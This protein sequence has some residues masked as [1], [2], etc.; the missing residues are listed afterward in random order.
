M[1]LTKRDL[2]LFGLVIYF[3]F[4]GGTFYSQFN[5]F[6]RITNQVIVTLI[7]GG[8]LLNLLRTNRGLPTTALDLPL[9]L[10]L[11]VNIISAGL[12]YA[13]RFS[14]EGVWFTLTHILAFY[15]LVDLIR[16]GRTPQLT[17]AFFMASAVVC[18]IGLA[19][20]AAWYFG[21]SL[22]AVFS[23]GWS[24]I[25]GWRNPIPPA[26]YRLAITLNGPT[27]LSAYLA[28]FTPI[29]IGLILT[30]PRRNENRRALQIWL[31]LAFVV[32]ILT[33]SRA[34]ILALLASLSLLGLGWFK[35]TGR[36]SFAFLERWRRLKPGWRLLFLISLI[37]VMGGAA[38]WLQRSF[39]GRA[40]STD[41]RLTLWQTAFNIFQEEWLTG[42]GPGNFGRAL[43]RFNDT[44]LPRQQIST[45]HSIYFNTAA[46]LGLLG[47]LAGAFLLL[48]VGWIWRRRW[49]NIGVTDVGER[50]KL[51]AVGAA[52]VGLAVQTLVDT[53]MAT[54][55]M[56]VMLALV[57]YLA[58]EAPVP[59]R[60]WP[61]RAAAY[62]GLAGL[63]LYAGG[64][65]WLARADLRYRN[66]FR[67]ESRGDLH[68]AVAQANRAQT[69]DPY[70]PLHHF[71]LGL[72]QAR[73]AHQTGDPI[74]IDTAIAHYRAGLQQESIFGL[75]SANLAGLLWQRGQRAEA[76][77]MMRRTIAAEETVLY[78]INL[79]Y[80][81]EQEKDWAAAGTAYGRALFLAP[82]IAGSEF[83]LAEPERGER[84][85]AFVAA[86]VENIPEADPAAQSAVQA[87]IA[88]AQADYELA[89]SLIKE[90]PDALQDDVLRMALAQA[91]LDRRQPE[92]AQALLTQMPRTAQDYLL[93]GQIQLLEGDLVAAQTTLK[94][95]VFLNE[96]RA[97]FYL[98]QIYENQGDLRAAEMAYQRGF[99][100]RFT[101]EN[102]EAIIYGRFSGNDLA[103]QLLPYRVWP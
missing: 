49:Q 48:Q 65:I 83:W 91:Y 42:A 17:W 27:A 85:S 36:T 79:G 13:P 68:E 15:V 28:L 25:G 52:L 37:V 9:A 63:V 53:Y 3:T 30:L 96:P 58:A 75:N 80:F 56:L 39:T 45:A 32:Q 11:L 71:R 103:P 2:T 33:F 47:L 61:V 69:L 24:E 77:E 102:V 60:P 74:L 57:A 14:F 94:T 55:N 82:T 38:F 34:G 67:Q 66:S 81:Y 31:I 19:E 99:S 51:V 20:F 10:Y 87:K 89:D 93:W 70:L 43:L 88:L 59:Q 1:K 12:G 90:R 64:F 97:Y 4:I 18:L 44:L 16:R 101:S 73:Q 35:I 41:F 54:P 78:L 50:V 23:Q 100:P 72:L 98:G 8:W 7:L 21:S 26:I 6:I 84:G 62:V 29:A 5:V 46:E 92:A 76:I 40:G 95:A 86:A 22:F